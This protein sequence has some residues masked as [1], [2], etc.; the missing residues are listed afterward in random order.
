MVILEKKQLST[1]KGGADSSLPL[2]LT[3]YL[4][5]TPVNFLFVSYYDQWLQDSY[6]VCRSD[7][8]ESRLL[9]DNLKYLLYS[10]PEAMFGAVASIV[11]FS[12]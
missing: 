6:D 7:Y 5:Y 3:G 12:K 10:L 8:K 11:G 9:G 4:V 1:V 2:S